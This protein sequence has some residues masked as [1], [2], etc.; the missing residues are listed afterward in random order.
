MNYFS[1]IKFYCRIVAIQLITYI[2]LGFNGWRDVGSTADER[3]QCWTGFR[4]RH[5]PRVPIETYLWPVLAREPYAVPDRPSQPITE[6]N[7]GGNT[8]PNDWLERG[9]SQS[10]P[11]SFWHV[12]ITV[13]TKHKSVIFCRLELLFDK[14]GCLCRNPIVFCGAVHPIDIPNLYRSIEPQFTRSNEINWLHRN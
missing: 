10:V 5:I 4:L 6:D 1:E 2:F 9:S 14:N 13:L 3:C 8:L 11:Y 12:R 7:N